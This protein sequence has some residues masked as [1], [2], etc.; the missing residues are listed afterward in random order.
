MSTRLKLCFVAPSGSGKT[1]ASALLIDLF[2][3]WG[4]TVE[5]LKLAMPLYALQEKIYQEC[6]IDGIGDRQNH[7]LLEN[8]ATQMRKIHPHSIIDNFIKRLSSCKSDIV[9]NDDLRD[10]AVDYPVMRAAGFRFVK[11]LT[12]EAVRATRLDQRNDLNVIVNSPLDA[13]LSNI[14]GDYVVLNDGNLQEFQ[15]QLQAVAEDLRSLLMPNFGM[16]H[17]S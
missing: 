11:V 12:S 10:W 5:R 17:A 1:T 4:L 16:I 2:C 8:L 15:M 9:I 7:E 14:G 3:E 6:G 13:Q